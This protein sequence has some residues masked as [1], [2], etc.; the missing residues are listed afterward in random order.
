MPQLA[1][2]Q[3]AIFREGDEVPGIIAFGLRPNSITRP[4]SFPGSRWPARTTLEEHHYVY[5]KSHVIVWR[6]GLQSWP[7]PDLWES[8]LVTTLDRLLDAGSVV[9]W[10]G[11]GEG[12]YCDPPSLFDQSCMSGCVL[13]AKTSELRLVDTFSPYAALCSLSD[14]DLAR[15]RKASQHLLRD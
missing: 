3:L 13:A 9:S 6:I 11:R 4:A 10:I 8:A 2:D 5:S 1:K 15:L 14:E 12:C 7:S